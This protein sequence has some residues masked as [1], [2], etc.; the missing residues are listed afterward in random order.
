MILWVF[1]RV[2]SFRFQWSGWFS[3][4]Q[5][6]SLVRLASCWRSLHIALNEGEDS[7][8]TRC[9]DSEDQVRDGD[10]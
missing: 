10:V 6:S 9:E 4:C 5:E 1:P 8:E 7:D 2:G 3:F